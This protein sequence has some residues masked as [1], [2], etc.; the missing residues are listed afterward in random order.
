MK[1]Q[2]L[3]TVGGLFLAAGM[4]AGAQVVIRIGPPAPVHEE[5][6][7][8]PHDGWVYQPGYQRYDG[9]HYVWVAGTWVAPPRPHAVWVAGHWS[10]HDGVWVWTEGHWR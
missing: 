3:A 4:A 9:D 6:G 8:A 10:S 2:I 1:K 7:R 5:M